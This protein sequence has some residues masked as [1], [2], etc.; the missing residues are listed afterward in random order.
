MSQL[1]TQNEQTA[2]CKEVMGWISLVF[3]NFG[4]VATLCGLHPMLPLFVKPMVEPWIYVVAVA[5]WPVTVLFSIWLIG[6]GRFSEDH[7]ASED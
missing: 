5:V 6:H 3:S 7:A 4:F 2:S 1:Q